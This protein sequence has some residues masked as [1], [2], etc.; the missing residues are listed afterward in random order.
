MTSQTTQEMNYEIKID[1]PGQNKRIIAQR[2][3]T[4]QDINEAITE[5]RL[6]GNYSRKFYLEE[7]E[8]YEECDVLKTNWILYEIL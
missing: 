2:L 6:R 1:D 3:E 5:H 4:L 8:K 7:G